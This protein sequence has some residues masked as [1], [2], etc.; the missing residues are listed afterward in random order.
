M[1]RPFTRLKWWLNLNY[2]MDAIETGFQRLGFHIA[3]I[4]FAVHLL[5]L[6]GYLINEKV[7]Q[8]MGA[9]ESVSA[10]FLCILIP[11]LGVVKTLYDYG[12]EDVL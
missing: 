3:A 9:F 12:L 4:T 8:S 5:A 1:L 7:F 6:L 2:D 11:S 10:V